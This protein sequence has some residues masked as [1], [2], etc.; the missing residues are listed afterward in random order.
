[1]ASRKPAASRAATQKSKRPVKV[2]KTDAQKKMAR[3]KQGKFLKSEE[4]EFKRFVNR[5]K[6]KTSGDFD[7]LTGKTSSKTQTVSEKPKKKTTAKKP[8]PRKKTTT[9]S[10]INSTGV[11]K[12]GTSKAKGSTS[13]L[14]SRKMTESAKKDKL[15]A[16]GEKALAKG[17]TA[18][19]ARIRKRYDKKK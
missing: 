10:A 3:F 16:K 11:K 14:K 2:E 4:A 9:S 8:T 18:K 19:A 1:M 6:N 7:V 12:M 13:G 15:R 17:K 5:K